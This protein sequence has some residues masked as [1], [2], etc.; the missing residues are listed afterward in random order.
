MSDTKDDLFEG[1]LPEGEGD[2]SGSGEA[3]EPPAPQANAS[4]SATE[5]PKDKRISDLMSQLQ[6]TQAENNRLKG[7]KQDGTKKPEAAAPSTAPNPEQ[8][9]FR[10]YLKLTAQTSLFNEDPRLKDFGFT[11]EDIAG[12]SLADMRAKRKQL[13]SVIEKAESRG[14]NAAFERMGL[15]ASQAGGPDEKR[16]FASMSEKEIIELADKAVGRL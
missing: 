5:D 4:E 1:T 14:L 7:V 12:D 16:D 9:E 3:P 11:A 8:D 6:T 13:V 10:E 15:D 2:T